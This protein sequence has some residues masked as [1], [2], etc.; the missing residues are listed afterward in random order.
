MAMSPLPMRPAGP[1]RRPLI[2]GSMMKAPMPAQMGGG[3]Q[4]LPQTGVPPTNNPIPMGGSILNSPFAPAPSQPAPMAPANEP[5][6]PQ[7]YINPM[8]SEMQKRAAYMSK[9]GQQPQSN[10]FSG[11]TTPA[12]G[13]RL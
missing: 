8:Q 13:R 1:R 3:A 4:P 2:S 12:Y 9:M 5:Y 11:L 10:R 7:P 6:V